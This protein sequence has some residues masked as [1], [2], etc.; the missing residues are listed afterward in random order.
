MSWTAASGNV[1][2][3]SILTTDLVVERKNRKHAMNFNFN[4]FPSMG[5]TVKNFFLHGSAIII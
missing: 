5:G 1:R 4:M 2:V 3:V